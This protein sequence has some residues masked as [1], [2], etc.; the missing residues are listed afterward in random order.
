MSIGR[1]NPRKLNADADERSLGPDEMKH[2]VNISVDS[3]AQG[4]GGVVKLTD[5]N[6]AVSASDAAAAISANGENT[7]I[8]SVSDE[9]LG[10]V[11]FFVHNTVESDAIYAYS[12]ETNTYRLIFK[13]PLLNFDKDGFVKGDIVRIKRLPELE[14]VEVVF[15]QGDEGGV[16]V[17][18]PID[19]EPPEPIGPVAFDITI[20][21]NLLRLVEL[22]ANVWSPETA[23]AEIQPGDFSATLSAVVD[24]TPSD[25]FESRV[26]P[27]Q[28]IQAVNFYDQFDNILIGAT[29]YQEETNPDISILFDEVE[30]ALTVR[31]EFRVYINPAIQQQ[32]I[33]WNVDLSFN[34]DWPLQEWR[35]PVLNFL[36]GETPPADAPISI[37]AGVLKENISFSSSPGA[38][39]VSSNPGA[40]AKV[41]TVPNKFQENLT[42]VDVFDLADLGVETNGLSSETQFAALNSMCES[43]KVISGT[44]EVEAQ[45]NQTLKN[46]SL[47]VEV[48]ID[49]S[50]S[51]AYLQALDWA[52]VLENLNNNPN[53]SNDETTV[54]PFRGSNRAFGPTDRI[55]TGFYVT[56][57]PFSF[58]YRLYQLSA[59]SDAADANGNYYTY[60]EIESNILSNSVGTFTTSVT[61]NGTSGIGNG[62]AGW[63][64]SN[65]YSSWSQ[66]L[67]ACENAAGQPYFETGTDGTFYNF[68]VINGGTAGGYG[69]P[70]S[71]CAADPQD[72][73]NPAL[74]VLPAGTDVYSASQIQESKYIPYDRNPLPAEATIEEFAAY[75]E[76]PIFR[77]RVDVPLRGPLDSDGNDFI[78]VAFND[79]QLDLFRGVEN[80]DPLSGYEI[81]MTCDLGEF[82]SAEDRAEIES[83][84]NSTQYNFVSGPYMNPNSAGPAK[85]RRVRIRVKDDPSK[86]DFSSIHVQAGEKGAIV[87]SLLANG[88]AYDEAAVAGRLKPDNAGLYCFGSGVEC[89]NE[90]RQIALL[91]QNETAPPPEILE[92]DQTQDE[93]TE[94]QE[95]TT[96][97]QGDQG[98]STQSDTS[99]S[100]SSAQGV[101]NI[102]QPTKSKSTEL[103]KSTKSVIKKK[104]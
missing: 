100:G 53:P 38:S 77:Y 2:A 89:G 33:D 14:P 20:E 67:N 61:E 48:L 27:N 5:G 92:G 41:F 101:S 39:F 36:T 104:Y 57:C 16:D 81:N 24:S 7:V 17:S 94:S 31:A 35:T 68:I 91:G 65:S 66:V 62:N 29:A 3:D 10:V 88:A 49:Y 28:Y 71:V 102:S 103:T 1:I 56:T 13:S 98:G 22:G 32:T 34:K 40:L 50:N 42:S 43:L 6:Q 55:I 69:T 86:V 63:P 83:M 58:G 25:T 93:T 97:T 99:G 78:V 52:E 90:K 21:R 54:N 12:S 72:F 59:T 82:V 51:E 8:G 4:D 96:T 30:R 45:E 11:Y 47:P 44:T 75:M 87:G 73:F 74:F 64:G 60:D 46:R 95:E 23:I 85:G 9:E 37:Q 79:S 19:F 84:D 80:I 26:D 70:T 15:N 18:E 76:N